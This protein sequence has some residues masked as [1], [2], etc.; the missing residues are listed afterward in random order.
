MPK[1]ALPAPIDGVTDAATF[2]GQPPNATVPEG[3]RN[4]WPEESPTGRERLATRDRLA[5]VYSGAQ[6]T[7]PVQD[8]AVVA[9]ASAVS[10]VDVGPETSNSAGTNRIVGTL[11]CNVLFLDTDWTMLGALSDL[12]GDG[13]GTPP[14]VGSYGQGGFA[15][16]FDQD[17]PNIAF[18]SLIVFDTPQTTQAVL[19]TLLG[20][21]DIDADPETRTHAGA[22]YDATPLASYPL[23]SSGQEEIVVN[24]MA[25]KSPYLFTVCQR[26]I[27]VH[28]S[29][30]LTYIQRVQCDWAIEAQ[31]VRIK[32]INGA[33]Y[34]FVAINGSAAI[35]GPVVTDSGALPREAYGEFYRSSPALVYRINYDDATLRTPVAVN[36]TPLTRVSMPQGTQSGDPGYENHRTFRVSEYGS[37]RPRGCLVYS[38]DIEVNTDSEVFVYFGRTN[39]GFGY[40]GSATGQGP[41]GPYFT[42]SKANITAAFAATPSTYLSPT[43][44]VDYGI[45]AGVGGWEIDTN[46]YR[47]AFAWHGATWYNDIPG[48]AGTGRP[49]DSVSTSPSIFAVAYSSGADIVVGAGSRPSASGTTANVYGVRGVDG[50]RLWETFIS[51]YVPQNCLA[52]DPISGNAVIGARRN[53]LWGSGAT[54]AELFELAIDTGEIVRTFDLGD[55]IVH[56]GYITAANEQALELGCYGVAVNSRGQVAVGLAP[57]RYDT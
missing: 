31:T 10:G 22:C 2:I 18:Y 42:M 1:A 32:T 17:N 36:G 4:V 56:N 27:Y 28:K 23:P 29:S 26:Y 43:T 39:Q 49:A 57:Y 37:A 54:K 35:S 40:D 15:V 50:V 12:R 7:G 55:S 48:I 8:I 14:P 5:S 25:A 51:D 45:R 33:D 47:R 30:D 21:V 16:C 6:N 41:D 20:R 53:Q 52:I 3:L 9:Q 19:C 44:G 24:H 46:S 11:R 38:M 34:L 13:T